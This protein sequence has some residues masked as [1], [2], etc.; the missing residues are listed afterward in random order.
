MFCIDHKLIFGGT[1]LLS[2]TVSLISIYKLY[3]LRQE[4]KKDDVYETKKSL[5][6][7]LL[8]HYGLVSET[9]LFDEV[10][11]SAFDF[12][13]RCADLCTKFITKADVR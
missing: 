3:K 7:Y 10:P 6:E 11:K 13:K 1:L 5:N 12:P 4:L 9:L 2:G 8:L